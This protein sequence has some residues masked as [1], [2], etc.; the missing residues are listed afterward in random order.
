MECSETWSL[1]KTLEC[2]LVSNIK[3]YGRGNYRDN[4]AR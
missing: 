4:K 2:N 3:E 1:A